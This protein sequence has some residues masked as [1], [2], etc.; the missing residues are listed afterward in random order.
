MTTHGDLPPDIISN[1]TS[2]RRTDHIGVNA[3]NG[4]NEINGSDRLNPSVQGVENPSVKVEPADPQSAGDIDVKPSSSVLDSIG[5]NAEWEAQLGGKKRK[6]AALG[7]N[8]SQ[9]DEL[10]GVALRYVGL[11]FAHV[12]LGFG[13]AVVYWDE[14][15][16]PPIPWTYHLTTVCRSQ[17]TTAI[18][19]L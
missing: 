12:G 2:S 9:M 11:G 5:P 6:W 1:S 13:T 4:V 18:T 16:T 15:S 14:I 7:F 10:E 17:L 19:S 8:P 3:I